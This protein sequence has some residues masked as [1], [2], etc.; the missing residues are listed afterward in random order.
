[1]KRM[2]MQTIGA[3][4]LVALSFVSAPAHAQATISSTFVQ[5]ADG[6]RVVTW[7]AL[8]KNEV[9]SFVSAG[10][11]I[12]VKTVQIVVTAAGEQNLTMQGS[13]DGTTWY[14]LTAISLS[15]GAYVSL[16]GITTSSMYTIIEDPRFIRPLVSNEAGATAVDIDILIGGIFK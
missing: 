8:D 15:A 3:A 4:L 6:Y 5:H 9:G 10:S 11:W 7:T 13:M 2:H 12:S 14:T 1:M 16:S